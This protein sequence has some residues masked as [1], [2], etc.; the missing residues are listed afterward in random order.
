MVFPSWYQQPH[1]SGIIFKTRRSISAVLSTSKRLY[2]GVLVHIVISENEEEL[3]EIWYSPPGTNNPTYLGLSSK[4]N[5]KSRRSLARQ[6]SLV[7]V[8]KC[9]YEAQTTTQ[10]DTEFLHYLHIVLR[11][12]MVVR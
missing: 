9:I 8:L 5:G 4:R 3:T 7:V 10:A 1:L 6:N 12:Q 2:L 11:L